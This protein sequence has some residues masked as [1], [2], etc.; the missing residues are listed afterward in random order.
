MVWGIFLVVL[1]NIIT[2]SARTVR[3]KCPHE[4]CPKEAILGL[5]QH[6]LGLKRGKIEGL[7]LLIRQ[8]GENASY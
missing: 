2:G 8:Q 7:Q 6:F 3:P 5:N 1:V 4:I